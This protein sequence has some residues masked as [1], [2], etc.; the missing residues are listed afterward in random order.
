MDIA[1]LKEKL[2]EMEIASKKVKEIRSEIISLIGDC[3]DSV[4]NILDEMEDCLTEADEAFEL[5]LQRN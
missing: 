4:F 3:D 2:K 1:K 5:I